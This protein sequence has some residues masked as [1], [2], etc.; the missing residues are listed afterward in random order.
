MFSPFVLHHFFHYSLSS[1]I[2]C[3]W[4]CGWRQWALIDWF[5]FLDQ[6]NKNSSPKDDMEKYNTYFQPG[7]WEECFISYE[8][9]SWHQHGHKSCCQ[10]CTEWNMM[11]ENQSLPNVKKVDTFRQILF[12]VL[13]ATLYQ[14][15]YAR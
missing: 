2:G 3:Q 1:S 7:P 12:F 15:P 10:L 11:Y 6:D 13:L 9:Q 5:Y 4:W 14:F 8:T